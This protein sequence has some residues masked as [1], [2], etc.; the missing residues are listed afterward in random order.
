ML[1][2]GVVCFLFGLIPAPAASGPTVYQAQVIAGS[3]PR[4]QFGP[5]ASGPAN[6]AV[7][8]TANGVAVDFAGNIYLSDTDN[9]LVRK[10]DTAGN[11]STVAGTCSAG[12]S[13]DGGPATSAQLNQPYGVAV[14]KA[15]NVYVAD[16]GNNRVRKIAT[17]GIITTVAGNGQAL[18]GAD[19]GAAANTP[20]LTPRNIAVD[21]AGNL[22]ISEFQGHCVKRVAPAGTISTVAGIGIEGYAGDGGPAAQAQLNYPLGVAVDP[23]GALY[24]ADSQNNRVRRVSGGIITTVLGPGRQPSNPASS[25]LDPVGLAV[26]SSGTLYVTDL[27]LGLGYANL[28]SSAGAPAFTTIPIGPPEVGALDVAVDAAGNVYAT[29]GNQILVGT[30]GNPFGTQLWKAGGN[31]AN[32]NPQLLAGSTGIG[33]G[34]PAIQAQLNEPWGLALDAMGNLYIADSRH[35]RVRRISPSGQ[36][37][38]LAGT[39][40]GFAGDNGPATAAKLNVPAGLAVDG[41]GNVYVADAGNNRVREITAGGQIQTVVGCGTPLECGTSALGH[42]GSPGPQMPLL[43][44]DGVCTGRNG[45]LYVVDTENNRVLRAPAGGVVTTAAGNGTPG[46]IGDGGPAPEAELN[47]PTACASDSAG[48]LFIADTGNNA[49]RK[50]TPD[51]RIATVAGTG[52]PG[53]SGDGGPATA[54]ALAG[55]TGIAVT[56]DGNIYIADGNNYRIRKVTPDGAIQTILGAGAVPLG[57]PDGIALDGSGNVYVADSR[58]NVV[59]KLTPTTAP[60]PQGGG[61]PVSTPLTAASAAGGQAGSVAPGE[62]ISIYGVGLGPQTGVSATISPGGTLP[63]TLGGTQVQFDGV[64]API[65]YAQAGQVNA[66]VPYG[67]APGGST[68]MVVFYNGQQAGALTLPVAGT[69]PALFPVVVNQDGSLNSQSNPAPQNSIVTLYGTGEGLTNWVNVP[70]LPAPTSPPFPQPQAAVSLT[71]AGLPAQILFAGSAPGLVGTIQV[72]ARTPGGFLPS[73]QVPLVLT[74]GGVP[75]PPITMWSK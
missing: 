15:G 6:S 28:A 72:N 3:C 45:V 21:S 25:P 32:R 60:D 61:T 4:D 19:G 18:E 42:D 69:A 55:P 62:L 58:R 2:Y 49:I 67:V 53:F 5:N 50:V 71:M 47:F 27:Y 64:P 52:T 14:D 51:G 65:L 1:R 38:T 12:Y 34:G 16:Y 33:D 75:S 31:P 23:A 22:Y 7:L 20:L 35:Q 36:I 39:V 13:G 59:L 73:G 17:N 56:D 40:A 54:A 46:Y 44:P 63:T 29:L 11:I 8:G 37:A 70:G 43:Q 30:T 57:F 74:V 48:D 26:D 10:I 66:Q 68:N 24:I 41:A 9:H